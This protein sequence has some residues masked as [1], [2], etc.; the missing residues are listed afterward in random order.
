MDTRIA[1]FVLTLFT[2]LGYAGIVAAMA[3]ENC[4]IPLPSEVVM[5]LAG[6]LAFQGQFTVW[7]A[8][9]AGAIGCVAGSAVAYTIGAT[10][11]RPLL[12]RSGRHL[13]ISPRDIARADR[14][15]ARHGDLAIFATRLLPVVRTVISLPAGVTHMR[16]GTFVLCTFLGSLGWC[17]ALASLGYT[18]GARWMR[19]G[20]V[21]DPL[22][23]VVI[24]ALLILAAVFLSRHTRPVG[25]GRRGRRAW[26]YHGRRGRDGAATPQ[27]DEGDVVSGS[28]RAAWE[29]DRSLCVEGEGHNAEGREEETCTVTRGQPRRR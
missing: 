27:P 15:F 20:A 4:C 9:V 16:V 10:G 21:L 5:P 6:F 25:A 18:L 14:F 7:G 26:R 24:V 22:T 8:S 3:I 17:F 2:T 23:I 12:L 29:G 19:I 11:G 13:L 28:P 1:P